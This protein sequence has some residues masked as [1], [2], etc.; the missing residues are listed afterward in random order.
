MQLLQASS[1]LRRS[2]GHGDCTLQHLGREKPC[3]HCVLV[4]PQ[5]TNEPVI[6]TTLAQL[7]SLSLSKPYSSRFLYIDS[8]RL[9]RKLASA[10]LQ[11]H[12][13]PLLRKTWQ[14]DD[15]VFYGI[16]SNQKKYR[17]TLTDPHLQVRIADPE[18]YGLSQNIQQHRPRS[19]E[20]RIRNHYTY[21][22]GVI[23]IELACQTPLS[24]LREDEGLAGSPENP[25]TDFEAVNLISETLSTDMGIPFQKMVQKCLNCDFGNGADLNDPG[26]QAAFHKDVVCE[27]EKIERRLNMLQLGE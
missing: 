11:F 23:L 8:I 16:G 9:A 21:R 2:W 27:L 4:T 22:L 20:Q 14:S 25:T 10:I 24:K 5:V 15:I 3:R 6:P 26:L 13:T 17:S 19:D 18:K 1:Q 7:I 12:A